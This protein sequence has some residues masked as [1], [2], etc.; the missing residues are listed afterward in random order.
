MAARIRQAA[1]AASRRGGEPLLAV[2]G[3]RSDEVYDQLRADIVH[4]LLRPNQRLVEVELAEALG[5]SRTPVREA[6][7]RLTLEGLVRR[8][9]G[10]WVVHEH[11]REEIRSIYEVRAALEGYAAFLAAARMTEAQLSAL[12]ELYPPGDAALALGPDVQVEL[13][14]RFHDGVIAAAGNRRLT[15][16]S[17]ASRQYYFNH[18]IARSYT[19]EE[20]RRSIDG[21][22]RILAALARGDGPA[23]EAC[24]REHVA[25]ALSIVLTKIA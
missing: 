19:R 6:L 4:G 13:N 15:Q 12:A 1:S 16:L 25:Y 23:A 22:G 20:T 7:Q 18:R 2:A 24:A 17:R 3:T 10:G 9:R 14:E 8:D 11:S 5:V 21:H